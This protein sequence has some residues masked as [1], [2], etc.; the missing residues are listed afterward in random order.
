MR[1]STAAYDHDSAIDRRRSGAALRSRRAHPCGEDETHERSG[2]GKRQSFRQELTKDT[3]PACA[4]RQPDRDLLPAC[5]RAG[6]KQAR[7]IA[8]GDQHHQHRCGAGNTQH[9]RFLSTQE[10][11]IEIRH[12]PYPRRAGVTLSGIFGVEGGSDGLYLGSCLWDAHALPQPSDRL[13]TPPHRATL[14]QVAA[15]F[16]QGVAPDRD[17]DIRRVRG[18][19]RTPRAAEARR[20]DT[21]TVNG[22]KL[23]W[24]VRP[25]TSLARANSRCQYA[26]LSTA[27]GVP[28]GGRSSDGSNVRP[29]AAGACSTRK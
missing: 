17:P 25:T 6:K 3:S 16:E 7:H 10:A 19:P 27:T 11:G 22:L 2:G 28:S 15:G 5:S 12:A 26:S 4:E 24:M 9:G 29:S 21:T 18:A 14:Q 13:Q 8:A 23:T 20:H 1:A